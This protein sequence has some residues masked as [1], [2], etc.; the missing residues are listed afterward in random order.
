MGT[1][2]GVRCRTRQGI[3]GGLVTALGLALL[4]GAQLVLFPLRAQGAGATKS[5]PLTAPTFK[6]TLAGPSVAA[7][8]SSGTE[9][10]SI[11]GRIVVADTGNNRIEFYS[12]TTGKRLGMFGTFGSGNGQFNSPR[13]IAIDGSGNIYVADAGNS[14]VQKFNSVGSFVWASQ[15]TPT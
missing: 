14:R 2:E 8:Y 5:A 6:R 13:D 10:D 11:H 12:A 15:G 1:A 7:M 4:A 3:A 9:W